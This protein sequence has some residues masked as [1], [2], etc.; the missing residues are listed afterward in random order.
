MRR[1]S[2]LAYSMSAGVAAASASFL[3]TSFA[4]AMTGTDSLVMQLDWK[5]NVQF[6]G[7]L[8]A[9]HLGLY[10]DK[11]L[12]VMIKPWESNMIVPETV[13]DSAMTIGC[14][15]Q[16][17]VSEAQAE[18]A[19]LKAI[20]TMFQ[21]SPYALM[22]MPDS[23][24]TTLQDL[25]GK[26]VGVHVDG[27]KVMELVKGVNGIAPDAIEVIE[28]PYDNKIDRL[29]NGEL[30][31]LQCY[32]VDEPIAFA[33]QVG[34]D[35]I[36]LPMD[37]YGYEAYAQTFFTT[38]AML[39]AHGDMV[40]AFLAASFAGW[41]AALAD[42]P[43]TAVIVAEKYAEAGSKYTD[44]SYQTRSLELVAEYVMRGISPE[45]IGMIDGD[46]WMLATNRMA[47]YGIIDTAPS[48]NAALDLSRWSGMSV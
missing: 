29:I 1:R 20:A 46:R 48:R 42:I 18:G 38:D 33:N 45:Q 40:E 13:R 9:D 47:E 35:P 26:S 4:A 5:F 28:I 12:Q 24:I 23:G 43:G 17:L 34:Q 39:A 10:A 6:A 30:A 25:I 2:F 37:A 15:E 21:S 3:K 11:G 19:R 31:A 14:S 27:V 41:S 44:V 8:M 32:A 7:L 22:T 36:L 16:N